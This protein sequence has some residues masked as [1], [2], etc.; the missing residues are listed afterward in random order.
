VGGRFDDISFPVPGNHEYDS[1][2]GV[3]QPYYDYFGARACGPDGYT[4]TPS[5]HRR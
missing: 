3:A 1:P 2:D 5:G 4:H